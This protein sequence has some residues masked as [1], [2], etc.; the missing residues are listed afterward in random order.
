MLWAP[1]VNVEAAA[2]W[3]D[4]GVVHSTRGALRQVSSAMQRCSAALQGFCPP[5]LAPRCISNRSSCGRSGMRRAVAR[6]YCYWIPRLRSL[7]FLGFLRG[8]ARSLLGRFGIFCHQASQR[9]IFVF[10]VQSNP[11]LRKLRMLPFCAAQLRP[12]FCNSRCHL[13]LVWSIGERTRER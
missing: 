6:R 11:S 13:M 1:Y 12:R 3:V 9:D 2:Y 4:M 10:D 8:L 5:C 7:G